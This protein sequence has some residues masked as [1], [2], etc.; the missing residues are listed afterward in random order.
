MKNNT[1]LDDD[2]ATLKPNEVINGYM[3]KYAK[4]KLGL[5]LKKVI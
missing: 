1:S 4:N 2:F 5:S 3:E